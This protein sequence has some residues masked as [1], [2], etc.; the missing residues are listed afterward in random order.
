LVLALAWSCT[1]CVAQ[2][3]DASDAPDSLDG[4][5][6]ALATDPCPSFTSSNSAH[7]TAGRAY[8]RTTTFFLI[9]RTTYF[10]RGTDENLGTSGTT[11]TTLFQIAPSVFS[12]DSSKCPAPPMAGTGGSGGTGGT[13][14]SAGTGTGGS[15]GGS[16]GSGGTAMGS[17]GCGLTPP[18]SGSGKSITVNGVARSYVLA[19][20][21]G[22]DRNRA[23]PLVLA[24]HGAGSSGAQAQQYFGVQQASAG[25]AILVYPDAITRSGTRQWGYSGTGATEDLGFVDALLG[26][27]RATLCI[28][29][30]RIFATGHSSG[31]F[32]S[33]NLGCARGNVLR[34]IAPVAG[35][36]P[37]VS[38][39]GGQV[40]AWLMAASNDTVVPPSS[41][42]SSRDTWL[43][44]NH[45]GTTT[46]AV[47]PGACV[48]YQGCDTGYPV[49]WCLEATG[50]HNWP[51]YGGTAI[52]SF[53]SSL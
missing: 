5:E 23:Y 7:V 36:G 29:D 21:S 1:A 18:S 22:Y 4:L 13:G 39:D 9:R 50:G 41:G 35:G 42:Q 48:A 26:Q 27:L 17:A 20:P 52:W 2:I 40:A 49:H 3:E 12:R 8:T 10:A 32:F 53:F 16:A 47:G 30:A 24:F 31:G 45:C 25:Q 11:Q 15:A 43:R 38:C 6:A 37:F 44:A 34:A 28:D 51:S 14:G 46:Q 33:N 19:V